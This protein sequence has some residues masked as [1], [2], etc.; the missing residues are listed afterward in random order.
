M[1][2][3]MLALVPGLS[4]PP[5]TWSESENSAVFGGTGRQVSSRQP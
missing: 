5:R 4:L 2:I 1:A 3:A